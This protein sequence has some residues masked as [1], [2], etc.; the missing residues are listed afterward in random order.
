MIEYIMWAISFFTLYI[1]IV[2]LNFLY[3]VD[4]NKKSARL[5]RIPSLTLAVPAYNEQKGIKDT[6]KSAI[7]CDYPKDKISI[8]VVNDGST[9]NT[10][11]IVKKI[12][13]ENPKT[14]IRLINQQNR[15]KAAAVNTALQETDSELFACLD[16][17]SMIDRNTIKPML[18]HF[19]ED[20]KTAAVITA[21]KVYQPRNVYEKV[22][23]FEYLMAI[24]MRKIRSTINTLAMTP[25]VLS[26]YKT[27]I[28]KSLGGFD[29]NNMTEDF[30]IAMRL[31]YHGYNIQLET[32][33]VT[34]TKVPNSFRMLWRQRLR[35]FRGY[36]YNHYKYRDMFFSSRHNK[37]L[38]YFQ[39]PLNIIS[40]FVLLLLIVLVSY[41]SLKFLFERIV[42]ISMIDGYL[43]S[44]F[45]LPSLKSFILSQNVKIMFP[46]YIGTIS[47]AFLFYLAHRIMNEKLRYPMSIWAY[48]IIFPYMSFSHWVF[49]LSHE[50]LRLKRKW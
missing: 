44:L 24:L 28:L 6:L 29:E 2:W 33:S 15:G 41:G 20:K 36:L 14:K 32:E 3:F 10:A 35:W 8:I 1:S 26:I 49:S 37:I 9:D 30:E 12:I 16:A 43:Q 40:I 48:F 45:Y 27:D 7:E 13:S 23:R 39:L 50:M 5:R 22:Q 25:G 4:F 21:I 47:G 17:D 42:R 11:E 18:P 46:I 31:K 38:S 34:Y 19:E